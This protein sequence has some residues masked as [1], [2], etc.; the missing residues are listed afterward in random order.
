MT[1]EVAGSRHRVEAG[2][3]THHFCSAG[4]LASFQAARHPAGAP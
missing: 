3:V 4:C 2:G 1:V